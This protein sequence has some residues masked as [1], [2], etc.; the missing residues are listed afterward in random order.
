MFYGNYSYWEYFAIDNLF[1]E[2]GVWEQFVYAD[3]LRAFDLDGKRSTHPIQVSVNSTA[4]IDEVFDAISYSKGSCCVRML[5]EWL[6]IDQ[7]RKAIIAYLNKYAF[8]NAKTEDLW[9]SLKE[10]LNVDAASMMKSWIYSSGYP[11]VTIKEHLEGNEKVLTLTQNRY[12]EDG[13]LDSEDSTIWYIPIS[14]VLCN[15]DNS[16]TEFKETMNEKSM[17]LRIPASSKWIKFNKNQIDFIVSIIK[18]LNIIAN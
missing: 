5:I 12:L 9:T 8:S 3:F 13:G 4:E 17:I 10:S 18:A 1:P 15:S 16:I 6:G 7:F 11:V 14:Y 2:W